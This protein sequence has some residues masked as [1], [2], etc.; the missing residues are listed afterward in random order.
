M[1]GGR[2]K[3]T[4]IVISLG[5]MAALAGAP[6]QAQQAGPAPSSQ[7]AAPPV[8]ESNLL[9][10]GAA[11]SVVRASSFYDNAW[12]PV[13]MLDEDPRTGWSN[14]EGAAAP[15]EIVIA[16]PE[17][18]E[19]RRFV[20]DT[21]GVENAERSAREVEVLV[22]DTDAPAAYQPVAR[23]ALKPLADGQKLDLAKPAAGRFVKLVVRSNHGDEKY[24]E[25]MN[26]AGYG[27]P[28]TSTPLKDVSG[29]YAS[30][31]FGKFHL[32]QD[33]AHLTGCYEHDEGLIEG[34]LEAHL[35][36]LT[37]YE[38][39]GQNGPALM[40]ATAD[41]K[42]F[43]GYWR[44]TGS[45]GWNNDWNLR[46]ISNDVGSC[47]HWSPKGASGNVIASSLAGAKRVRLYGINFDTDSDRLRP[48]ARSSIDQL[49]AALKANP[50]WT[51]TI[52]GHTD[53]S[54]NAAHNRDLS[55]RRAASVQA[56]LVAAGIP[57]GRLKA[58]GFG[59][60]QPVASNETVDGRAQNR[61]VEA[62][63]E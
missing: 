25:I 32:K 44:E 55:A 15:H 37:W 57:A 12:N 47:P 35:L 7:P 59:A 40:V 17:R 4:A 60:D 20:F 39:G 54:G 43:D 16:L 45:S 26:V 31:N 11:A 8:A 62:V 48:D 2:V 13:W 23:I 24:A 51:L 34:G 3:R 19:L 36:R 30:T 50:G 22:A 14:A 42:G 6:A 27:I 29:T 5:L 53:S 38:E 46:K 41:G 1:G 33:G 63:R 28:L 9:T 18:S 52:G 61:R 56:A 49:I 10:I 21:A 58:S